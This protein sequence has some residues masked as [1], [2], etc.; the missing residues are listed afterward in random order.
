M[1]L[2]KLIEEILE[3]SKRTTATRVTRH[4]KILKATGHL[5]STQAR[6]RNDPL[7]KKMIYHRELYYKYR[8]L[9]HQK[10]EL[11]VIGAA[12]R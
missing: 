12:R 6:R 2:D 1:D 8:E 11:R 3:E 10:Y 4:T 7:Y 5:A 9:V